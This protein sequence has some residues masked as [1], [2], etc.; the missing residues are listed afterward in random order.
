MLTSSMYADAGS[1]QWV[2]LSYSQIA[3]SQVNYEGLF[4]S[5]FSPV[6]VCP[7]RNSNPFEV[8][9]QMSSFKPQ[10]FRVLIVNTLVFESSLACNNYFINIL[11]FTFFYLATC[12][13][14]LYIFNINEIYLDSTLD[15]SLNSFLTY[16]LRCQTHFINLPW[17]WR[18]AQ[19]N[20]PKIKSSCKRFSYLQ[21]CK[22]LTL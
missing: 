7:A 12:C 18:H 22:T 10:Y 5:C 2:I 21:A 3:F 1:L 11:I 17:Y 13:A 20:S 6:S 8:S 16:F 15:K 4:N 19:P 14:R 9:V